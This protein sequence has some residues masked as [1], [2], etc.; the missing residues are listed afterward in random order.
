MALLEAELLTDVAIGLDELTVDGDEQAAN[1]R[2]RQR[3]VTKAPAIGEEE[4]NLFWL[5]NEFLI[6]IE[7]I[8]LAINRRKIWLTIKIDPF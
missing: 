6:L 1:S 7:D 3:L 2:L 8:H 4:N 5:L